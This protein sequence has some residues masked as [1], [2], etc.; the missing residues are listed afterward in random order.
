ME[1]SDWRPR[2]NPFDL[3]ERLL[4]YACLIVR[5][6]DGSSDRDR[7]AKRRIVP[8]EL[9]ESAFRLRVLR[10]TGYLR[11]EHDPV[12]DETIELIKIVASLIRKSAG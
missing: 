4:I 12:L 8:R 10:L 2:D 1:N 5:A 7:L 6:D 3:R 9:K 11:A